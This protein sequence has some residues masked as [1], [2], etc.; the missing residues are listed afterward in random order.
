MNKKLNLS[1]YSI[2][3]RKIFICVGE[4]EIQWKGGVEHNVEYLQFKTQDLCKYYWK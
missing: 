2:L 3:Y 1:V 4:E